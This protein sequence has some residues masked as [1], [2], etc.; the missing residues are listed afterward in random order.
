MV[1]E[2]LGK[3]NC[4]HIGPGRQVGLTCS[5]QY[6]A[7]SKDNAPFGLLALQLCELFQKLF[8][9]DPDFVGLNLRLDVGTPT[10]RGCYP[11]AATAVMLAS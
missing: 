4:C 5:K 7:Q 2:K 1:Q 6:I 9:L 8:I 11:G 3:L 10:D